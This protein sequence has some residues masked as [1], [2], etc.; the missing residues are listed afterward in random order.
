[1]QHRFQVLQLG[2]QD[3]GKTDLGKQSQITKFEP[4]CR[5]QAAALLICRNFSINLASLL[6]IDDADTSA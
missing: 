5:E 6:S 4:K 3:I 1:M 2:T